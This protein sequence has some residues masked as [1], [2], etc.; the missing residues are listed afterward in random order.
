MKK[1]QFFKKMT[2]AVAMLVLSSTMFNLSAQTYTVCEGSDYE[3]AVKIH[4]ASEITAKWAN[5]FAGTGNVPQPQLDQDGET[6][7]WLYTT[8]S[9]DAG[10]TIK[11][12][13]FTDATGEY[14]EGEG[15]AEETFEFTVLPKSL[16]SQI[17]VTGNGDAICSGQ[18]ADLTASLVGNDINNPVFHWYATIDATEPLYTGANYTTDQ[19]YAITT[20][21]VSVE[22]TNYCEGDADSNGRKEVIVTVYDKTVATQ[23]SVTGKDVVCKGETTTLTA[24]AD[25]DIQNPV[26]YWYESKDAAEWIYTG[27]SFETPELNSATTYYVSVEGSNYC[28]GEA[29]LTGR[30]EVTVTVNDRPDAPTL[31]VAEE[32][33]FICQEEELTE[34]ILLS[35]VESNY[36]IEFYTDESCTVPFT[37]FTAL[38]SEGSYTIY[39]IAKDN[40]TNCTT[41]LSDKLTIEIAV[42]A[43]TCDTPATIE[44]VRQG[45]KH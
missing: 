8:T 23:I 5:G 27:N 4:N 12:I 17:A 10:K 30:K 41:A 15:E 16:E 19:L 9:Q 45:V 28:E 14:C 35:F 32:D 31:T 33:L 13:F 39:A 2:L 25:G 37:E 7:V 6:W 36:D 42:H 26:F 40:A 38:L 1:N 43:C 3:I 29:N 34:A 44:I 11:V 22:G 18:T 20:Y 24:T 21:Y